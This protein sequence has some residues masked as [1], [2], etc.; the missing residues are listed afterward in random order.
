MLFGEIQR[1]GRS[2]RSDDRLFSEAYVGLE[3][4]KVGMSVPN[5]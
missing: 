1:I 2:R 3:K 5:F 4:L